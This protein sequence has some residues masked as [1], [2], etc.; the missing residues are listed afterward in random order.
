VFLF[1]LFAAHRT[2]LIMAGEILSLPLFALLLWM[3]AEG[4]TLE[5][6]ALLYL[7][8]YLVYLCFTAASLIYAS[9]NTTIA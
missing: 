2:W 7:V 3:F 4:M 1:G 6:T 8:S 9:R 5:R